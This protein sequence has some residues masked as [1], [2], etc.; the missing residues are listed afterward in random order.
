MKLTCILHRSRSILN[1]MFVFQK[2]KVVSREGGVV[3]LSVTADVHVSSDQE[4]VATGD[5]SSTG[6]PAEQ[7]TPKQDVS[8]VGAFCCQ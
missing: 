3:T 1:K 8:K 2:A 6:D 4:G 5:M 7:R